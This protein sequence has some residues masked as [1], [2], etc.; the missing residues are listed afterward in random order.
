MGVASYLKYGKEFKILYNN[1]FLEDLKNKNNL[2][3]YP[4]EILTK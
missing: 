3:F 1:L 4:C 2:G